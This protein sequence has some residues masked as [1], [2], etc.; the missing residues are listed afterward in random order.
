MKTYE[1][2]A[3]SVAARTID[4][5]KQH[6]EGLSAKA[7]GALIDL[8]SKNIEPSLLA[9]I[10]HGHVVKQGR[11]RGAV[12]LLPQHGADQ[13]GAVKVAPAE[14]PNVEAGAPLLEIAMYSN[15]DICVKG[16]QI[17]VDDDGTAIFNVD[18][19]AY[20]VERVCTPM[21]EVSP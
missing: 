20:L 4:A 10:K 1:P 3:G 8:P 7:I 9:A 17:S 16:H 18:Q 12:Y 2:G 21:I 11:N 14:A 13:A 6:P 5:L 15:G 19:M